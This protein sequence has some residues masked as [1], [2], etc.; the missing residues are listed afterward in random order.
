MHTFL[1][2]EGQ[3]ACTRE[4]SEACIE[5]VSHQARKRREVS[6][7]LWP[8]FCLSSYFVAVSCLSL[9]TLESAGSKGKILR[10]FGG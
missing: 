6:S 9:C 8:S 7:V 5:R 4:E 1:V 2:T 10:K 3:V